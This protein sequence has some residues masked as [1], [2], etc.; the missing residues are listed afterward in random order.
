M[1]IEIWKISHAAVLDFTT[2]MYPS[3][4]IAHREGTTALSDAS[5]HYFGIVISGAAQ[6][7]FDGMPSFPLA[8][9]MYFSVPGACRLRGVADAAV[10]RRFGY[11]GL[12]SVGG[13]VERRG[14]L[15]YIDGCGTTLL[16]PPPRNGDPCLNLL[17]FPP[18]VKQSSHNHPSLRL[19][20][21]IAGAG[22]CVGPGIR[23]DLRPGQIFSIEDST[24]H[25]FESGPDGLSV[26]AYHPESDGG[27]V[28]HN[29]P[30][31]NR[32]YLR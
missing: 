17:T 8:Q 25:C 12:F 4:L 19:G 26:V 2:G 31:L 6:L 16:C 30:M 18:N 24:V 23:E 21:V 10:F 5:S 14:R 29:H 22:V 3:Q 1:P 28:D 32:T 7:E 15:A 13:P 9:G 20:A 11:R 27:P